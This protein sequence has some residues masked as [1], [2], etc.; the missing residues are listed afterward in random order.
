LSECEIP[1][2][3]GGYPPDPKRLNVLSI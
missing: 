3:M 2:G 1:A